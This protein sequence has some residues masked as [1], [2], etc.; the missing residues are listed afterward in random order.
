MNIFAKIAMISRVCACVIGM[1]MY[2]GY[3]LAEDG[4][5]LN[6]FCAT[7]SLSGCAR[8]QN[9]ASLAV[10]WIVVPL[11]HPAPT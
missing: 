7:I 8:P 4:L 1:D 2:V 5:R 6:S 10:P 9:G 3:T 11:L